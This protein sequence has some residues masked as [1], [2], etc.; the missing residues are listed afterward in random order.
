MIDN[1]FQIKDKNTC[2]IYPDVIINGEKVI[3]RKLNDIEKNNI[4]NELTTKFKHVKNVKFQQKETE[5]NN[6]IKIEKYYNDEKYAIDYENHNI[7]HYYDAEKNMLILINS[8]TDI[9]ENNFPQLSEYDNI[10]NKNIDIVIINDI[11][12]IIFQTLFEHTNFYIDI[13][14]MQNNDN[15]KLLFNNILSTIKSAITI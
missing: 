7:K 9:N 3:T 2:H 10:E 14:K 8:I 4:K 1:I 12:S 15:N 13:T 6:M 5:C 11:V